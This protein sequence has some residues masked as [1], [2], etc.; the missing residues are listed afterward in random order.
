M[1]KKLAIPIIVTA[2]A[3]SACGSGPSTPA[4]TPAATTVATTTTAAPSTEA[5]T[6]AAPETTEATTTAPETTAA[7]A[8]LEAFLEGYPESATHHLLYDVA[9][10]PDA[11]STG[12]SGI[13]Y[14]FAKDSD[15][16]RTLGAAI[17]YYT[18]ID[19]YDASDPESACDAFVAAYFPELEELLADAEIINEDGHFLKAIRFDD[20]AISF[21]PDS[22]GVSVFLTA[23]E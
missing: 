18:A 17:A 20:Y 21:I 23:N 12:E 8:T 22:R 3:L 11:K 15:G 13:S 4:A 16:N 7:P 1:R 14:M 6:T 2:L 19:G 10:N 9:L 5:A